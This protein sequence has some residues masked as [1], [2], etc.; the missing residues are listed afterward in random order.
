[1]T[2][3][4]YKTIAYNHIVITKE[5]NGDDKTK[6]A[7]ASETLG[8]S[9][10]KQPDLLYM[11]DIL[12]S[13]GSNLNDDIFLPE[14]LIVAVIERDSVK[15]KP[16]NWEHSE[17]DIIGVMYDSFLVD[18]A[19]AKILA[20]Q[21]LGTLDDF[22]VVSRSVIWK[23]TNPDKA[24]AIVQGSL[25]GTL[26]VSMEAFFNDYDYAVGSQIVQRTSETSFL[27]SALRANGGTGEFDGERVRRVLRDITFGGKGIVAKPANPDSHI[28]SVAEKIEKEKLLANKTIP[29]TLIMGTINSKSNTNDTNL[30]PKLDKDDNS[31]IKPNP[32]KSGGIMEERIKEL[33]A[34]IKKIKAERDAYAKQVEDA[35]STE[36]SKKLKELE[37]KNT[38]C[39]EE[40]DKLKS[41][42]E[43]KSEVEKELEEAKDSLT[44]ANEQI[45]EYKG[46]FEEQ[47]K[48]A[49][50][51]A[52][53]EEL[54]KVV[55]L[56]GEE[57]DKELA[58]IRDM[59]DEDFEAHM[60]RTQMI[61]D[62]VKAQSADSTDADDAQDTDNDAD[63]ADASDNDDSDDKDVVADVVDSIV[64]DTTT[65]NTD[66]DS[67][68]DSMKNG[69]REHFKAGK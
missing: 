60:N 23:S 47:E 67:D 46:K 65:I 12:V 43:G 28:L 19:G 1:M 56:E 17:R 9:Q 15:L 41:D 37:D 2:D 40:I 18:K 38:K 59:S 20:E 30:D 6:A 58:S 7:Q 24:L 36:A 53:K 39:I 48:D 66:T 50:L 11:D 29:K 13:V 57:L 31:G 27:D 3:F 63:K 49:R 14:E 55:T 10:V 26:F 62:K 34:E 54:L 44:K 22:D 25:D 42:L 4:K 52:R 45:D 61:I 64:D 5:V 69:F 8:L 51:I 35:Q 16:V 33:E 21:S 32:D 68:N